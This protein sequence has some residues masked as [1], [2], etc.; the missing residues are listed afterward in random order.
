MKAGRLKD[1]TVIDLISVFEGV[2]SFKKGIIDKERLEEIEKKACPTC[3]SC[4]GM[5]TA[6]SMNCLCEALGIA[7]PGNGTRLAIS[8]ERRVLVRQAGKMIIE[9]IRKNIKPRDI[10]TQKSVDNALMLDMA[11]GGSTNTILHTL[12]VTYEAGL[13]YP[14]KRIDEISKT[15]PCICKVSPS[16]SYHLEDVDRVGGVMTILKELAKTKKLNLN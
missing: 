14:L 15:T 5:F 9:L 13:D 3:G 1:G 8:P 2:G 12:A 16:S 6:N 4:S 10:I 7:L 11:M